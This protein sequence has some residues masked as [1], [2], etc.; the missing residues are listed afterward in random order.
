MKRFKRF[1]VVCLAGVASLAFADEGSLSFQIKGEAVPVEREADQRLCRQ[2]EQIVASSSV[3]SRRYPR[4]FRRHPLPTADQ[5]AEESFLKVTYAEP[6]ALKNHCGEHQ[7]KEVWILLRD[8]ENYP[9]PVYLVDP[10]GKVVQVSKYNGIALLELSLDEAV[11]PH[12]PEKMRA[13]QERARKT[14]GQKK[15]ATQ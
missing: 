9:G 1:L 14:L 7:V 11:L 5:L 13:V 2:V 10:E 12:L 15:E 3:D 6:A 4:I 8:K